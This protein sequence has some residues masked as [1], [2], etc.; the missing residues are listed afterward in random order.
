VLSLTFSTKKQ[1]LG[2]AKFAAFT[3][4]NRWLI[5]GDNR[6]NWTSQDTFALGTSTSATD[7]VKAE[8]DFFRIYEN[9]YRQMS[10]Q[11]FAGGGLVFNTH[12]NI[13]PSD[14]AEGQWAS[15]PHVVYSEMHGLPTGS[16]TSGGLNAGVRFDSRDNQINATRGYFASATYRAYFD[17]FLNGDSNWQQVSF[18]TRTYKTLAG[19]RRQTFAAWFFGDFVVDGVAPYFDLPATGMDTFGRSG[20]GYKEGRFRGEKLM[21]AEFEYRTTLT[22]NGLFGMVGFVNGTTVSAADSGTSLFDSVAVG[23]GFGGRFLLSKRS[24]ANLCFDVGWGRDG[25][26]GIYLSVQEVF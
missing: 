5:E 12:V 26:R 25:S 13:H 7:A 17:G 18:D 4:R 6:L 23:G 11:L 16:A 24:R 10:P 22:R 8:Y 21:Y 2:S 14:E 1:T 20:R 19:R 9:V 15:S 3:D